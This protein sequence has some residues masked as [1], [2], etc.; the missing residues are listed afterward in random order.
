MARKSWEVL[1]KEYTFSQV[2]SQAAYNF[3]TDLGKF[4]DYTCWDRTNF[5]DLRGSLSAQEWQRYKSGIQSTTP[6]QRFR[7]K[8]GQIYID[9][10]PTVTDALVIEYLSNQ[11]VALSAA[12]TV[13]TKIAFTLDTDVSII[14]EAALE[15][16]VIWR[17]LNRKGLAYAEE[18][19]QADRYI[20]ELFASDT[21]KG[22]VNLGDDCGIW[23]PLPSVP[24]TGYS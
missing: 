3:P 5:W 11:W 20:G 23:P 21:P 15:M 18:K 1:Q 22:P 12:P 19:D 8:L 9:P 2:V 4:A 16:E 24:W 6:R 17:F 13:A 14:D 7:V 10:T